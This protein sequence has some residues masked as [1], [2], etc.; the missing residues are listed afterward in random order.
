MLAGPAPYYGSL[1]LPH[2]YGGNGGLGGGASVDS[3]CSPHVSWLK[4]ETAFVSKTRF[5]PY[6]N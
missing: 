1:Y 2:E 6:V 4:M 3:R 5:Y